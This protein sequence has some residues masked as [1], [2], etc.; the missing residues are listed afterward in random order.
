MK[1]SDQLSCTTARSASWQRGV[2]A[3][4]AWQLADIPNRAL[5]SLPRRQ[6]S[7]PARPRTASAAARLRA[8]AWA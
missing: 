6:L 1:G 4:S 5:V 7:A 2:S 8:I 3:A